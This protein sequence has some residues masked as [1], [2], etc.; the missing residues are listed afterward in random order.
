M[1]RDE[2]PKR[3][4]DDR[5][6]ISTGGSIH[7]MWR[8]GVFGARIENWSREPGMPLAAG[9]PHPDA[10]LVE[11]ALAE[12]DREIRV[13]QGRGEVGPLDLTGYDIG[14]GLGPNLD[15]APIFR[16]AV[17]GVVPWLLT[18][19]KRGGLPDWGSGPIIAPVR[20]S[21]GGVTIW[22]SVEEI[23][24]EGKDGTPWVVKTDRVTEAGR[25]GFYSPG[26][27]CKVAWSRDV[28]MVAEDR[29]QYAAWHCGCVW[30]EQRLP[31]LSSVRPKP[32]VAPAT[33]W[34]TPPT[35]PTVL[36]A[37]ETAANDVEAATPVKREMLDRRKP[38]PV[39]HIDP[40]SYPLAA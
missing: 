13:D 2:L 35:V 7:P 9:D 33:P 28:R 21:R 20:G 19:A 39:R 30:L 37:V 16:R 34:V 6:Y 15:L 5:H 24:G 36:R 32:P 17:S 12:L 4:D 31:N 40:A 27:F 10:L 8:H 29:A 23:V 18:I 25:G 11:E 22:K 38:E 3:H 26:S 14:A 1:V